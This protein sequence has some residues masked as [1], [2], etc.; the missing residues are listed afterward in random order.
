MTHFNPE[1][2]AVMANKISKE[3]ILNIHHT[4]KICTKK[5]SK[6]SALINQLTAL[7]LAFENFYNDLLKTLD[8]SATGLTI[9]KTKL[10]KMTQME[11][12]GIHTL[13]RQS[14]KYTNTKHRAIQN[15][16]DVARQV[17]YFVSY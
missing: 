16:L 15:I 3:K 10:T 2:V 11:L 8:P 13:F 5:V 6:K 17:Q 12:L 1:F 7:L 14:M 4:L 9:D